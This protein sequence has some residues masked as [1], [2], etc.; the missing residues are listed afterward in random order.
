MMADNQ[1]LLNG[2]GGGDNIFVYTGGGQRVPRDVKRLRIAENVDTIPAR[3]FHNCEQLI[4]VEGHNELKRVQEYAFWSCIRLRRVKKMTGLIEIEEEAF[5]GCKSLSELDFDKLEK[6]GN[7]AFG[8]CASLT[9]ITLPSARRVGLY[10]FEYCDALTDVVFGKDLESIKGAGAAFF[11]CTALRSIFIPLKYG[12]IVEDRA[13]YG[14]HNLSR[15]D[16]LDEGMRIHKTISSLH[17]ESWRNEMEDEINSINQTLP[18]I[19]SDEKAGA[20][21]EWITRVLSR[22]EH[23]RAEHKMLVREAMTLLELALWKA[24]LLYET[25]EKKWNVE[26]VTKKAKIDTEVARKEQRVTCGASVVI[27]NVLPFLALK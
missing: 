19:R 5:G 4:E 12:L 16:A 24:K 26:V 18:N 22:M 2:V 3:T 27:K 14:C 7:G 1:L 25:D 6:I 8:E 23:Y 15:V 20:I 17:M 9:S 11:K 10:A 21:Q 13:F